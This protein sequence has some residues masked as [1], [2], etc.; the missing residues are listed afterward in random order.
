MCGSSSSILELLKVRAHP[1]PPNAAQLCGEID[2][3][4]EE[5]ANA[6]RSSLKSMKDGRYS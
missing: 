5:I 6:D 4:E 3:E 2:E 1:S